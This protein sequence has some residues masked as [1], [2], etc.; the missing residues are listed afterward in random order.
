MVVLFLYCHIIYFWYFCC[1]SFPFEAILF[2]NVLEV[3]H[4]LCCIMSGSYFSI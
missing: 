1:T 3:I 4:R 2:L